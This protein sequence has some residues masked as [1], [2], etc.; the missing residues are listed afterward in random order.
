MSLTTLAA[1]AVI[2]ASVVTVVYFVH[3]MITRPA[4]AG[5]DAVQGVA[6]ELGGTVRHAV[7]AAGEALR[8]IGRTAERIGEALADRLRSGQRDLHALR[9]QLADL[10]RE[11][12]RLRAQRINVDGVKAVLKLA[13]IEA[14]ETYTDFDRAVAA[15]IEGGLLQPRETLEYLGVMQARFTRRLGVDLEKLRFQMLPNREIAVAGLGT[16]EIIGFH[17]AET[18]PLVTEIRR[19]RTLPVLGERTEISTDDPG[20]HLQ[21][22]SMEQRAKIEKAIQNTGTSSAIDA[23][24]E[25]L[26][27]S[28]LQSCFSP[29][30]YR[31]VQ[32]GGELSEPRTFFGACEEVNRELDLQLGKREE[33]ARLVG[34]RADAVENELAEIIGTIAGTGKGAA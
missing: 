12:E 20:R 17:S 10:T 23:A 32:A 21:R 14:E 18:V 15:E 31:V 6:G 8:P 27:L 33:E 16:T 2:A 9:T 3:R 34:A 4:Q 22:K 5:S 25:K 24:I 26:A 19:R 11:T 28:F 29:A 13:L 1:I 7:D 30:G